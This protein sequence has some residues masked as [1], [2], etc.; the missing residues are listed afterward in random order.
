[1]AKKWIKKATENAH[2]Q[3]RTKAEAAGKSTAEYAKEKEH[4]PGK[5]GEQAR[6]AETLM[7]TKHGKK[8]RA[9]RLYDKK[10]KK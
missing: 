2:G 5:T 10:E 8:A 3:F 9:E 1:M 4:A 6:L 7:G